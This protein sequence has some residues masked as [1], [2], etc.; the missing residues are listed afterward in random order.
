MA[1]KTKHKGSRTP[2]MTPRAGPNTAFTERQTF[3]GGLVLHVANTPPTS[4]TPVDGQIYWQG[5][6]KE[7]FIY[8]GAT[9]AWVKFYPSSG[10]GSSL[11]EILDETISKGFVTKINF[12]GAAVLADVVG[13]TAIITITG[14]GGGSALIV[15]KDGVT[16]DSAAA[17]MNFTGAGFAVTS[18]PSGQANIALANIFAL[19]DGSQAFTAPISGVAPT[20]D[21]H[22]TTRGSVNTLIANALAAGA[23]ELLDEGVSKGQ[24]K[25]L[26][27][28]GAG[29]VA[30]SVDEDGTITITGG[31]GSIP[32]A[33]DTEDGLMSSADKIK[34]DT[35]EAGSQVNNIGNGD[36]VL[37][38][39]GGNT[40]LHRHDADRARANHTGTQT[41]ATI[42]D[43]NHK[44]NHEQGGGDQLSILGLA[45]R[46]AEAQNTSVFA[47]VTDLGLAF[48]LKLVGNSATIAVSSG[49]ATLT[50]DSSTLARATAAIY[51]ATR[52]S[53]DPAVAATPIALG[54]NDGRVPTQAENDALQTI[55]G[56]AAPSGTNW[57]ITDQDTRILTQAQRD[58][59]QVISGQA[60]PS[61]TNR[62]V[63]HTDTRLPTQNEK[64]ALAGVGGVP[65]SGNK[66]VTNSDTRLHT[67]NTDTHT[68]ANTYGIGDLV[69]GTKTLLWRNADANKPG[70]RYNDTTNENEF[71]NDGSTWNAIGTDAG[72][73][74]A[75]FL[76]TLVPE[77]PGATVF[78]DGSN[79]NA[80]A[81]GLTSGF[82]AT[83]FHNF[84][85]WSSDS[86]GLND[87]S[88][89]VR[90]RLP[91]NFTTW[92]SIK[93]W[94]KVIQ[95][96]GAAA[97]VTAELWDTANAA[98]TLTGGANLANTAWTQ[99]TISVG[100][101]TFAPG[102]FITLRLTLF[103]GQNDQAR[104][105][106]IFLDFNHS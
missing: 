46:A 14:G 73:A 20:V 106:E 95:S 86:T 76:D 16:I 93:L 49:I 105:G 32:L 12:E 89:V 79:N 67:Q 33:S 58:A 52:L 88:V 7:G 91:A 57:F 104:I 102:G 94:N 59:A 66:Y 8:N 6:D 25:S 65:G 54:E 100:G 24:V 70:L 29:G 35:V 56:Q 1:K 19:L 51:G 96:I 40:T 69:A 2:Q 28:V 64:D 71:S 84:Y 39:S 11:I 75:N 15:A 87:C 18:S 9:A 38:T 103:A 48:R 23:I 30:T 13:D 98:V 27:I 85:E 80:G 92:N 26:N 97:K 61:T 45:G 60:A 82:D 90:F 72:P 55:P 31:G 78:F 37:L 68:N 99:T 4:P 3:Q 43:F 74:P 42:S 77:Y 44:T 36:A 62:F 21:A 50:V 5:L 10:G 17:K 101:G 63:T 53:L 47:D 34:L 41:K 22:L 83:D 81:L